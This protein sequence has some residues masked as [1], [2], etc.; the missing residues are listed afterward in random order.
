MQKMQES[1]TRFG[2][3]PS[4]RGMHWMHGPGNNSLSLCV[5]YG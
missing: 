4:A 3:K 2:I 1:E 5:T